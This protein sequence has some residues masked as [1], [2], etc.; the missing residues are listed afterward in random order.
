[1]PLRIGLFA[2]YDLARAGGVNTQIRAQARALR[3][4][5]HEVRIY[6]A[7]SAQLAGGEV[8]LGAA[9]ALTIGGTESGLAIDPRS[10]ARVVRLLRSERFD[11]LHVHEPLMPLVAWSVL[12]SA[13]TP[14]VGTFH[15][16][17]EHGH[18]LYAAGRPWLARLVRRLAYRIAVSEAAR[19]TAARYFPG[20]YE[21]VPNGIDIGEFR[22]PRPRPAAFAEDRR[23]VVFVGRL[24]PRKGVEHLIRAMPAVQQRIPAARLVLVGDG[25]DRERLAVVARQCGADA[26]F[27][28]YV[29]DQALVACFQAA[30][31]ICSPAVGGESFGIVLLEAMAA[32]TPVVASRIEGYAALVGDGNWAKLVAPGDAGALA[33]EVTAL[34]SDEEARTTLR[35]RALAAVDRFDCARIAE[36][37]E[38]I[39]RDVKK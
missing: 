12:W 20:P 8:S 26:Q 7:A 39:Y 24:E 14:I 27:V 33:R 38:G 10:S 37:L 1:M 18:R 5:G 22:A 31:V 17:R 19:G 9:I 29:D 36:R 15:V 13:S 35:A 28:C 3:R 23:H 6:G 4:R 11:V 16:H 30:D 34:M 2:P 32:G 21:I 25:P